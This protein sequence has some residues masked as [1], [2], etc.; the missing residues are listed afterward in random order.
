MYFPRNWELAHAVFKVLMVMC[1]GAVRHI[2][3]Y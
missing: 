2:K 1:E 3:R